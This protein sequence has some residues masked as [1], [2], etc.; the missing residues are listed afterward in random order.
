MSLNLSNWF[1]HKLPGQISDL[2]ISVPSRPDFGSISIGRVRQGLEHHTLLCPDHDF[3][4]TAGL[5]LSSNVA[6]SELKDLKQCLPEDAR[7]GK[8]ADL[9]QYRAR[10][11]CCPVFVH[12]CGGDHPNN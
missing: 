4:S 3:D 5:S 6:E 11:A 1:R 9:K 7:G 8:P 2:L 12:H 10:S